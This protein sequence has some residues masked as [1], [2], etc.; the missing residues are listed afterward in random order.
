M[1]GQA[2]SQPFVF[3]AFEAISFIIA[4]EI[5]QSSAHKDKAYLAVLGL[6]LLGAASGVAFHYMRLDGFLIWHFVFYGLVTFA[7]HRKSNVGDEKLTALAQVEAA[8]T[9]SDLAEV[10][11]NYILVRRLLSFGLISYFAAFALTYYLSG[12]R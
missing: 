12:G 1:S 11:Q 4:R 8:R 6:I 9:G 7:W 3:I 10:K 5:V 2:W